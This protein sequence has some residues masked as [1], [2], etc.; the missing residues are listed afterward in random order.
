VRPPSRLPPDN[1]GGGVSFLAWPCALAILLVAGPAYAEP[2]PADKESEEIVERVVARAY[3]TAELEGGIIALPTAPI[4]PVSQG[5]STPFGKLGKGDATVMTGVHLLFR[6]DARCPFGGSALA[7][8]VGA[9]LGPRPTSD[10]IGTPQLPR[11]HSRSYLWVGGEARYIPLHR[12]WIEAWVGLTVGGILVADRYD[13]NS[14]GANPEFT[15]AWN[16]NEVT[17]RT[18]GLAFGPQ[19]GVDWMFADR[20]VLGFAI[21]YDRWILPT[22]QECSPLGDCSTL[23]GAVDAYEGGLTIGY[24][25]PL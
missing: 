13:N 23:T 22:S 2:T 10:N 20:F 11:T 24:R 15:G 19:I 25:L 6:C 14:G 21:R 7:F 4:S 1:P 12:R 16:L 5:G 3:T 8:G 18:E 17:V 9:L